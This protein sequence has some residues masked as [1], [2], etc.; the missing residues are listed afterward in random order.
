MTDLCDHP[1]VK[2]FRARNGEQAPARA[3]LTLS[4]DELRR[5]CLECGADDVGFV[6]IGRPELDDQRA[7]ILRLHPFTET[8]ISI[9]SR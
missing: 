3:V 7:E 8:L 1:T 4:A 9:V 6:E 2:H 5:L